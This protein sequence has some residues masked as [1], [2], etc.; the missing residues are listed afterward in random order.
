MIRYALLKVSERRY[1]PLAVPVDP[2]GGPGYLG[3]SPHRGIPEHSGV[4][5]VAPIVLTEKAVPIREAISAVAKDAVERGA[6]TAYTDFQQRYPRVESW[7][8]PNI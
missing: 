1:L 2:P 5:T 7:K 8:R 4:E 6:V 3:L